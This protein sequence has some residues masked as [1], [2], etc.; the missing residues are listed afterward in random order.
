[1]FKVGDMVAHELYVHSRGVVVDLTERGFLVYYIDGLGNDRYQMQL[2]EDRY[3]KVK[4]IPRELLDP[5]LERYQIYKDEI[6]LKMRKKQLQELILKK[7]T[8]FLK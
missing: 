7:L 1:M 8:E 6:N 2:N 4:E 3:I 5:I